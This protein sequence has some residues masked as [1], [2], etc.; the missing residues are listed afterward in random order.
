MLLNVA[1]AGQAQK[2][3][4]LTGFITMSTLVTMLTAMLEFKIIIFVLNYL[5]AFILQILT[6]LRLTHPQAFTSVHHK[7]FN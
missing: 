2:A 6:Q 1:Y 7:Q 3:N 4:S 5:A